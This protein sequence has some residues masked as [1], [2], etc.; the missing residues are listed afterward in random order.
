MLLS[1]VDHI[2]VLTH[3]PARMGAFYEAVFDAEIGP[4]RPHGQQGEETMTVMRIGPHTELNVFTVP[5]SDGAD[6][7]TPMWH[8]GRL[9]HF[10]LHAGSY[11]AFA[12]IRERLIDQGASDGTVNDFGGAFSMFFRD[13]DG[14]EGEVLVPKAA[15]GSHPVRGGG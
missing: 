10:G 5:S 13:P 9:D 3:D 12:T 2:A 1:G 7:Q 15:D 4:T 8:R 6:R 14:L 11:A